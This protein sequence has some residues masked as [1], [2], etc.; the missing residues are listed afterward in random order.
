MSGA[1]P[2]LVTGM[3]FFAN[4]NVKGVLENQPVLSRQ[5]YYADISKSPNC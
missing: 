4:A 3:F 5:L 2:A 1:T